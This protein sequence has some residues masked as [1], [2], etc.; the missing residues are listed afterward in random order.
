MPYEP[1]PLETDPLEIQEEAYALLRTYW[2]DWEPA[3]GNLDTI[4]LQTVSRISADLRDIAANVPPYIFRRFG[5]EMLGVSS[6][7][8]A[9]AMAQVQVHVTHDDGLTVPI[10]TLF[11]IRNNEGEDMGFTAIVDTVIP[12]GSDTGIVNVEATVPG[13]AGNDVSPGAQATLGDSL[14]YVDDVTLF[15]PPVNGEDPETIEEYESRLRDELTL[16]TPRPILPKDFAILTLRV[17]G[18]DRCIA[19]DLYNPADG[20]YDNE[21]MVTVIPI[22]VN[23]EPMSGPVKAEIKDMLE[24]LR[25]VNFIV[26]VADPNYTTIDVTYTVLAQ[27]GWS[28]QG[29]KD[30]VEEQL[31]AYFSPTNW[32]QPETG[33]DPDSAE[34]AAQWVPVTE[35]NHYE[36]ANVINDSPGVDLIQAL[37]IEGS[38]GLTISLTGAAPLT[39]PGVFTGTVNIP[40]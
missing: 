26:N 30:S 5:V 36:V 24:S 32:G 10:G 33:G 13:I 40:S 19:I 22:D 16:L 6:V 7:E 8:A 9:P 15:S 29:V 31:T 28:V 23:G 12:V 25:E 17:P 18:V 38:T 14:A 39:R 20:T 37:S 27:P 21:K 35:I 4:M 2:P 34:I 3:P 1:Y 11:L